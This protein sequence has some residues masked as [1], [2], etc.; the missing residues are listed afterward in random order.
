MYWNLV[1]PG[2][3]ALKMLFSHSQKKAGGCSQDF[4]SAC[5]SCVGHVQKHMRLCREGKMTDHSRV[6]TAVG[7]K[8]RKM[9]VSFQL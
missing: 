3:T 5:R 6:P 9:Y 2:N 7:G 4:A 8:M 1:I